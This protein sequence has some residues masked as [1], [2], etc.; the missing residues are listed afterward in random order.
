MPIV[1]YVPDVA[2][3]QDIFGSQLGSGV[4]MRSRGSP[5]QNG[6]GFP[7]FLRNIFSK[8][9]SFVKPLLRQAAPHDRAAVNAATPHLK[10]AVT[11]AIKEAATQVTQAIARKLSP[12]EGSGKRRGVVKKKKRRTRRIPPFNIPESF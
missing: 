12:Q 8:I 6:S 10:E 9:G 4:M 3:Y 11:G 1:P 7:L 2:R 5:Y